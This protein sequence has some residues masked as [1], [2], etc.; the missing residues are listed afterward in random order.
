MEGWSKTCTATI[1]VQI[2][3]QSAYKQI[4]SN[5]KY[6][7]IG[8]VSRGHVWRILHELCFQ[9][10][11]FFFFKRSARSFLSNNTF[12]TGKTH[13]FHTKKKTRKFTIKKII[14]QSVWL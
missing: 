4:E 2:L 10:L 7:T 11:F 3:Q 5:F 13:F 6:W 12:Y 1:R 9:Q 8:I 14:V